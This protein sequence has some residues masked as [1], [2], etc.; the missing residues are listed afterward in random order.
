MRGQW[1]L[2]FMYARADP[3][4]LNWVENAIACSL[5]WSECSHQRCNHICLGMLW[6]PAVP[7]CLLNNYGSILGPDNID[8]RCCR[9]TLH[10]AAW[11]SAR[12]RPPV[13]PEITRWH[14]RAS[15]AREFAFVRVH[16]SLYFIL[17]LSHFD[18][19][20]M[21][22]PLF[23]SPRRSSTAINK[24]R[25][26]ECWRLYRWYALNCENRKAKLRD[27]EIFPSLNTGNSY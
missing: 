9:V 26:R 24:P 1:G 8:P 20:V 14:G 23:F 19:F 18:D 6:E 17:E 27:R 22:V 10:R 3:Y 11:C 7:S 4:E 21:N 12:A 25:R 13:K 15:C 16:F 2:I 5:Y